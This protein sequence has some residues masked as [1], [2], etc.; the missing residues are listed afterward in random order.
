MMAHPI[1]SFIP[2]VFV[3]VRDLK[4]ATEWYANMLERQIVPGEYA[5]GIYIFDFGGTALILDSNAWGNPPMIMFDTNDIDSA[6]RFCAGHPHQSLSDIFRDEYVSVFTIDSNMICQAHRTEE[7]A[8]S[9]PAHPLLKKISY[10]LVHSDNLQ[11]SVGWYEK[12][13]AKSAEPDTRFKELPSIRMEKGA[14]LIMDDNRLCQSPRM[15]FESLKSDTR[16]NPIA[17]IEADDLDAALEKVSSRGGVVAHGI[18][19]KMGVRFFM[20][21]DPDSNEF[22]VCE[23]TS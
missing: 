13:V 10:V 20:F 21:A 17:V 1:S 19:T 11:E 12:L 6:H 9:K 8:T 16:V 15:F 2:A 4:S 14:D 7:P 22:M 18:E 23:R 5:D 3:P